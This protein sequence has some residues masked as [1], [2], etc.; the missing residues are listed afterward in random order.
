MRISRRIVLGGGLALLVSRASA[1]TGHEGHGLYESLR[2]PGRIGLPET[3]NVQRVV[4]SPAPRAANPGRWITRAALP[5]PRSE[6][7]WAA[8]LLGRMHLVGGYGEQRVDRPYHHVYD[9]A[10]DRWLAAA[11]LP[12]GAN[13]VGVAVLDGKLYA[14]GG[15]VE[16]N[17]TPHA[18][19]AVFEPGADAWRPIAPLP[20]PTGAVA[21]VGLGGRLHAIGGGDASPARR[22]VDWHWS[23]DPVGNRWERR[24]PLPTGRDH[25]GTLAVGGRI[26][27]VGGR[28]DTFYTN[29]N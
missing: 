8:E 23:Y 20:Q 9:Q 5:L 7:A 27:V 3:A 24:A 12:R 13:H 16:Q 4:D 14:V 25:T 18:E 28:V 11:P 2:E 21:C 10:A 22:S 17:R 1:Q 15:F 29:S 6:M 26:H 19:C